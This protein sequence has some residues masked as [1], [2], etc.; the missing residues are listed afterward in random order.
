MLVQLAE[1]KQELITVWNIFKQV[2]TAVKSGTLY[3][4]ATQCNLCYNACN[5]MN[6]LATLPC[7]TTYCC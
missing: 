3:Q 4:H 1:E 6:L 5:I 7:V 2:H